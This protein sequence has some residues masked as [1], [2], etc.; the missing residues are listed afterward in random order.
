MIRKII[1]INEDKCVGCGLCANACK[2]S[3]IQIIDGKAKLVSD[4]YC[5]GLGNCLPVCPTNAISFVEREADAYDKEAVAENKK[6]IGVTEAP[7][8]GCPGKMAKAI[9]RK[10]TY[11]PAPESTQ[12][13]THLNQ[14]PVQIKLVPIN[15]PYF[16]DANLLIAADCSAFSYGNFHNDFM[17][18]RITIIG[19][20]KLDE[21][22]YSEKLTEILRE[23]K[24]KSVTIVRMEVPCCGG[25]ERAA[26]NALRDCG[27]MIPWQVVTISTDG[28]ILK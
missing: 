19:C 22:D 25:I 7:G 23:N 1:Q 28:R 6:K 9:T 18:D 15:A 20:P 2:E 16:E 26:V 10:E 5:D 4:N 24:I 12:A 13:E 3:A 14:W 21:G 17:K 27:K 8:G 11:S